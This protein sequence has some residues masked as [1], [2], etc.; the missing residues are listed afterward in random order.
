[1]ERAGGAPVTDALRARAARACEGIGVG[2]G[3]PV[4]DL[5]EKVL[6]LKGVPIFSHLHFKELLAI[7]S[8]AREETHAPGERIIRQ[9]E[10]GY[11]LY[12]IIAGEVRIVSQA[13]GEVVPL[14]TLGENDYFGEMALF[15]DAPRSASAIA[16][17]VVKVL[18]ID[19]REFR[20]MLRE[21]PAVSIMMCEVFCRRL[22]TTIERVGV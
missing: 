5:M 6:T 10:H 21:Y 12:I 8:I 13:G 9:G 15:D 14:A 17:E 11:S 1:A 16:E 7:A 3:E 20:D 4:E 19:K 2:G 22:R 18:R